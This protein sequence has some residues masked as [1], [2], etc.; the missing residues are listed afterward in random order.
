MYWGWLV[1]G[2]RRVIVGYVGGWFGV[3]VFLLVEFGGDDGDF[4]FVVYLVVDDCVED[5]VGVL[6][7]D[8]VDDLRGGVH[9]EEI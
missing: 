9:F 6:V 4:D 7:G 3:V 2:S 1:F 8:V 5:D